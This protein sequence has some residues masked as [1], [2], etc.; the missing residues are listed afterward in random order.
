MNA[1]FEVRQILGGQRAE[2]QEQV[3]DVDPLAVGERSAGHH[4][5][6]GVAVVDLDDIEADAPIVEQKLG[7]RIEGGEDFRMGQ[8]GAPGIAGRRIEIEAEWLTGF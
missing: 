7:A 4:L 8:M 6:V 3:R 5:G 2:R 1:E